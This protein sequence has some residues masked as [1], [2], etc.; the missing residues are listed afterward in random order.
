[1]VEAWYLPLL[2]GVL[3]GIVASGVVLAL[4][5]RYAATDP[6]VDELI[7][8]VAR[9]A[10][11]VR[12]IE[13]QRVRASAPSLP[14]AAPGGPPGAPIEIPGGVESK[15]SLRRR[16]FGQGRFKSAPDGEVT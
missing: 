11:T 3:G 9:L 7:T 4:F 16:V 1:M 8:T 6:D 10:S 13:M 12:R 2:W 15:E 14:L 5:R